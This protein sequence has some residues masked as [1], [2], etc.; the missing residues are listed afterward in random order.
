M[1]SR[2]EGVERLHAKYG[3]N[4]FIGELAPFAVRNARAGALLPDNE[5]V[6]YAGHGAACLRKL[7][8]D[9]YNLRTCADF[10][11]R[12]VLHEL[13]LDDM[14]VFDPGAEITE[15][16]E[17]SL[18]GLW[19]VYEP[20]ARSIADWTRV[21]AWGDPGNGQAFSACSYHELP[22]YT[23][24]TC[25]SWRFLPPETVFDEENSYAFQESLYHESIHQGLCHAIELERFFTC[26]YHKA[27]E[28]KVEIPWRGVAWPMEQAVH[29]YFVYNNVSQMRKHVIEHKKADAAILKKLEAGLPEAL[30]SERVLFEAIN[31]HTNL[32]SEYGWESIQALG[33]SL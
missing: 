22:Q 24:L 8:V 23:F 21:I 26:D 11:L 25:W 3:D 16:I 14:R 19:D 28:T 10:Q 4:R 20:A 2:S 15:K 30:E 1:L 6:A 29:A 13:G 33:R 17:S 31:S 32:F 12:E 27:N 18:R 5:T 9:G 7:N